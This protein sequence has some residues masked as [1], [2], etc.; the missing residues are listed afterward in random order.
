ML[1]HQSN[2]SDIFI[3]VAGGVVISVYTNIPNA[4]VLLADWDDIGESN[5][6]SNNVGLLACS[7]LESIPLEL[8][9]AFA[10][11]TNGDC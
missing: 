8:R 5:P 2:P 11:E 9:Q 6:D 7:K 1:S 3:E 10:L 4:R